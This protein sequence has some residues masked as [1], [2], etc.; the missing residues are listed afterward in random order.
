MYITI[1][2]M[3]QLVCG[4]M[5]GLYYYYPVETVWNYRIIVF[6]NMYITGLV[7][8]FGEFMVVNYFK[9]PIKK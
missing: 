7:Y 6:F 1:A 3:A 2:Q 8:L 5:A 9:H 4:G